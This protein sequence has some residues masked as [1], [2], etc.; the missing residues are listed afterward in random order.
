[1]ATFQRAEPVAPPHDPATTTVRRAV[2]ERA[3][4]REILMGAQDNLTTVLAVMLGVSIG[5]G[6]ADL[7]ALAGL[8]AAVAEAVS[9]GGVLYSSTRAEGI[10]EAHARTDPPGTPRATLAP[11]QSG[12]VTFVAAL[13][14]GLV[15]LAPFAFLPLHAAIIVSVAASGIALFLLGSVIGRISGST[16]WRDGFRLLVVAGLAA[17]ASAV[18]GATLSIR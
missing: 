13:L 8:S 17:G 12:L 2:I 5:S 7:V 4:V 1:L 18:V 14:A 11:A 6:R 3:T 15:P 16:W 9:M 10:L